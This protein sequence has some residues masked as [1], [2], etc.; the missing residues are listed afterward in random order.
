MPRLADFEAW[1]E[2]EGARLPEFRVEID[3]QAQ[4]VRCWIPSEA[5][6]NFVVHYRDHT[7]LHT[8]AWWILADGHDKGGGFIRPGRGHGS[9]DGYP[10]RANTWGRFQFAP[11]A[12]TDDEFAGA[13]DEATIKSLG[14]ITVRSKEGRIGE[15]RI[16]GRP[17][18]AAVVKPL[19]E[20]LK[21]AGGHRVQS[22]VEVAK[23]ISSRNFQWNGAQAHEFIFQYR[24]KDMLQALDIMLRESQPADAREDDTDTEVKPEQSDAEPLDGEQADDPAEEEAVQAQIQDLERHLQELRNRNKRKSD[25]KLEPK[26]GRR[27]RTKEEPIDAGRFF[28]RGE[29]IDLT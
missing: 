5:G 9:R 1:I 4:T 14:T 16:P 29:I 12:L 10:V 11:I 7:K 28:T 27:K 21:K 19:H 6:K 18:S 24:P 8:T 23:R 26:G 2:V 13:V 17:T 20:K 3:E 25:G 15:T 22:G